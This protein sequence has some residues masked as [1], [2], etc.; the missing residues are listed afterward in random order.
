M[1]SWKPFRTSIGHRVGGFPMSKLNWD[2]LN[3]FEIQRNW[4]LKLSIWNLVKRKDVKSFLQFQT[5][6]FRV[7]DS[8]NL[9]KL[10]HW[11]FIQVSSTNPVYFFSIHTCTAEAERL[12]NLYPENERL[13]SGIPSRYYEVIY[14]FQLRNHHKMGISTREASV[15]K[16]G[17]INSNRNENQGQW[18][19]SFPSVL[20][21]S[22]SES[23]KPQ[24]E[25][26]YLP[27]SRFFQWNY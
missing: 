8:I 14:P 25:C 22:S 7:S 19:C 16:V 9:I 11:K 26:I 18:I 4:S 2:F 23:F 3:S 5:L 12:K 1:H 10:D 20:W 15:N 6:K 17:D 27:L 24:T 21:S 13:L